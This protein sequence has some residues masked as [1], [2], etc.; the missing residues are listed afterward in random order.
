MLSDVM[1][2]QVS[3]LRVGHAA[4]VADAGLLLVV[5]SEVVLQVATLVE[6]LVASVDLAYERQHV[7]FRFKVKYF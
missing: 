6:P 4:E 5:G 1:F 2:F 7:L 3:N